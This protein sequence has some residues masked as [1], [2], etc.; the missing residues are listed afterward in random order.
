VTGSG[1]YT[2]GLAGSGKVTIVNS[3]SFAWVRNNGSS[4]TSRT[5]GLAGY[6]ENPS[7]I[8]SSYAA[9]RV[10]ATGTVGG[11]AGQITASVDI[12]R[13]LAAQDTL[14]GGGTVRRIA[15]NSSGMNNYADSRLPDN[16][17][18]DIS[19][20]DIKTQT[21]YAAKLPRD[22]TT[23]WTIR[24]E[25][26]SYPYLR[27][28]NAPAYVRYL[29]RDSVSL[30]FQAI[31]DSVVIYRC[32]ESGLQ[33]LTAVQPVALA[34][35]FPVASDIGDT[36][37]FVAFGGRQAPSY[38]AYERVVKR[39]LYLA[40]VNLN[41]NPNILYG[42]T[43]AFSYGGGL[44]AGHTITGSPELKTT[45]FST[46]GH[47]KVGEYDVIWNNIVI[48]D[49][50]GTDVTGDY[51][52]IYDGGKVNVQPRPLRIHADDKTYDG[53]V[54]AT[55]SIDETS[56]INGDVVNLSG[57]PSL[58]AEF[59]TPDAGTGKS[60]R[61]TSDRTA[62]IGGADGGNYIIPETAPTTA[63]IYPKHIDDLSVVIRVETQIFNIQTPPIEPL[64]VV[65]DTV[66]NRNAP[67]ELGK[68]YVITGY[69]NN[70]DVGQAQITIEG[71]GNYEG[72][73]RADFW[74]IYSPPEID[75]IIVNN[76]TV[77]A[78]QPDRP[79]IYVDMGCSGEA[80][81]MTIAV[82]APGHVTLEIDTTG[83]GY[84]GIQRNIPFTLHMG[85]PQLRTVLIRAVAGDLDTVYTVK[86]EK[87]FPFN[88]LVVTR[89]NNTMTI[90]SSA[91]GME[92]KSYRWFRKTPSDAD[93]V[94]FKD[95]S[96]SYTVSND[97]A[98]LGAEDVYYVE[99]TTVGDEVI[100]TCEHI[101]ALHSGVIRIYP[102]PVRTGAPF[103][104]VAEVDQSLLDK[105]EI[106]VYTLAGAPVEKVRATGVITTLK[107]PDM[108]GVYLYI[109]LS[110]DGFRK[111]LKVTVE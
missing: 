35:V 19:L 16:S 31:P 79:Y 97:G 78:P 92:F 104:L 51:E 107:A 96:R 84:V 27:Y 76:E 30:D 57:V 20:N 65:T 71:K 111:E 72:S 38:P 108:P 90:L 14:I 48:K 45:S 110:K 46:S 83:T 18:P 101:P 69:A 36:L 9:G 42:D 4:S 44:S 68:D 75:E 15:G 93:F 103:S 10:I 89:W 23:V 5:G 54:A 1:D 58:T 94:M 82:S 37:A 12:T 17:A 21:T 95:D 106:H 55:C 8:D 43:L 91:L 88:D 22:F 60:V 49:A 67:L 2:G 47:P 13:S 33:R 100:R 80:E 28:Q 98:P 63:T 6:L 64:P 74:I 99:A 7:R 3:Y 59:E 85:R 29:Y 50:G 34:E 25:Q 81:S 41:G 73:V 26:K 24:D 87:R 109:F 102:N 39:K 86:V 32:R 70:T 52:I 62:G 56:V 61:V 11:L 40:P 77:I 53:S 66:I 105:A